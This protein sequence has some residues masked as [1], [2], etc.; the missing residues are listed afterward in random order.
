M[1][2]VGS[3]SMEQTIQIESGDI[4]N[5]TI[6]IDESIISFPKHEIA[7]SFANKLIKELI[8]ADS[9]EEILCILEERH[10]VKMIQIIEKSIKEIKKKIKN[11]KYISNLELIIGF[12][13]AISFEDYWLRIGNIDIVCKV[14]KKIGTLL[15]NF[16]NKKLKKVIKTLSRQL[17]IKIIEFLKECILFAAKIK[18]EGVQIFNLNF[19]DTI[20]ILRN[21]IDEK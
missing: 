17:K 2:L 7:V 16:F 15:D 11:N 8:P 6:S 14:C 10:G 18:D 13:Y 19:D 21:E 3:H 4:T 1:D 12:I 20:S 9:D 5:E